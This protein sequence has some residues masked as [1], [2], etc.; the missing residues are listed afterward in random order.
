MGSPSDASSRPSRGRATNSGA[1]GS[2]ICSV[3]RQPQAE[4]FTRGC[5][6]SPPCRTPE[7]HQLDSLIPLMLAKPDEFLH[8]LDGMEAG[9]NEPARI[10]AVLHNDLVDPT[11]VF[12]DNSNQYHPIARHA[13]TKGSSRSGSDIGNCRTIL[14]SYVTFTAATVYVG[15]V[16]RSDTHQ[17]RW[18]WRWVSLRSTHPTD[19][20]RDRVDLEPGQQSAD[21]TPCISTC[22]SERGSQAGSHGLAHVGR[23][24]AELSAEGTTEGGRIQHPRFIADGSNRLRVGGIA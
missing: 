6:I 10:R 14:G 11:R 13:S 12:T 20:F 17:C 23:A 2:E 22:C 1:Y 3:L 7:F 21:A 24:D 9:G 16:E 4:S 18:V 15:W 5:L 19:R 8:L